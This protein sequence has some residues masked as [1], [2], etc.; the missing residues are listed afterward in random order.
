MD[1]VSLDRRRQLSSVALTLV[2][3]AANLVAFNALLARW[4]A[5]RVDLTEDGLYSTSAATRRLLASLDEDVFA[6]GYF[7]KRTHPKLAPLVPQVRDLLAEYQAISRGR[8]KYEILD[9]REDEEIEREATERYGVQST[10][11]RLASKYE[12][13]I[14]NAYFA[15]VVR[16][17]DQYVR[18]GFEDLIDVEPLPDGDIDV[19]FRNLEYDLTRAIKKVVYG[20][21]GGAELFERV[22]RPVRLVAIMTPARLPE[23]FREI[24]EAVRKAA[25]ELEEKGGDKFAFEEIDPS[26]DPSAEQQVFQRYGARPMTLGLFGGEPFYLYGFLEVGERV[27]Q[28]LLAGE[29]VTAATI[30]EAV[31]DAL[32][33]QTPGFL[34]TL[35]VVTPEPDIPPELWMQLQ[36]QGR[37][38]PRPPE[39]F[40]QVK[41]WLERDYKVESV[42]LDRSVPTDVDVLLVLKPKHLSEREVYHLD[43]YLMR[44]GRV[45]L[46]AGNYEANF[47]Q[48]GLHLGPVETGLR[49]WLAHYGIEI[50]KTLVLDDRNQ[51]LPIPEVRMTPL[52]ALR[53]WRLEPYPY[54]VEV[55][56]EGLVQRDVAARLRAVG[57][58][59]GSPVVVD[60]EKAKELEV[61]E[62]LKSSQRS[63]TDDDLSQVAFVDYTVPEE[64]L[65]PR[66]LGVALR[67]RFESFF[68]G[69]QP[70]QAGAADD[71]DRKDD[72]SAPPEELPLERSPETVLA[73]IGNAEFLSDFVARA[74]GVQEGGFFGENL[75]FVQNLLD[76]ATLDSDMLEIRSRGATARRLE[77]LEPATEAS[78]EAAN[79]AFPLLVL[80]GLGTHRLWRRRRAIPAVSVRRAEA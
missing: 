10:P 64:G 43:Q 4:T 69:K 28:L 34:K 16:F 55:R 20:F 17:G 6:Y 66:L 42:S 46:C 80:F 27:E 72:T 47:D 8:L 75:A 12:A 21:R 60:R 65:E 41:R 23:V 53:T 79:Y 31:E 11:F 59:W 30:R 35:G 14:V 56:D 58:Y 57:I 13:G 19:R 2:L 32:R 29:N 1:A 68:R 76:W 40:Q 50:Q 62:L 25:E 39:E 48:M 45:V 54:L 26:Q 52:G 3:L 78:V 77:H 70:P 38:P 49:D 63:W 18:Y 74:L 51:P 5:A 15:I 73:V 7:S 61:I 37:M 71:E 67:G 9:P 24:P 36:A 22:E 33:R 44:G